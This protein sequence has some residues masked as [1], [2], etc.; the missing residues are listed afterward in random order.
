MFVYYKPHKCHHSK[1][2]VKQ[3]PFIAVVQN[4]HVTPFPVSMLVHRSDTGIAVFN[5]FAF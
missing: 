1:L 5:E 4:R 2:Y 3:I